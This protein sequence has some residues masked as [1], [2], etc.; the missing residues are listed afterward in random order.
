M[1]EVGKQFESDW[2]SIFS[3]TF[4]YKGKFIGDLNLSEKKF[5]EVRPALTKVQHLLRV[6][7]AL[8]KSDLKINGSQPDAGYSLLEYLARGGRVVFDLSEL[9]SKQKQDFWQYLFPENSGLDERVIS[10]H[11]EGRMNASGGPAEGK[12]IFWGN[13][14]NVGRWAQSKMLGQPYNQFKMDIPA[15]GYG[16][17]ISGTETTVTDDGR[18]GSVFIRRDENMVVVGIEDCRPKSVMEILSRASVENARTGESHSLRAKASKY[19]P[20]GA[21]KINDKELINNQKEQGLLPLTVGSKY[22]WAVAKVT[23]ARLKAMETAA[24]TENNLHEA[25]P[26]AVG[27]NLEQ[28][29]VASQRQKQWQ[30][31]SKQTNQ[32][33]LPGMAKG[34]LAGV[35][36]TGLGIG[37]SLIPG[38]QLA[39]IAAISFGLKSLAVS[40]VM[41][42]AALGVAGRAIYTKF[43]HHQGDKAA[44]KLQT[45]VEEIEP[46]VEPEPSADVRAVTEDL[47]DGLATT[48][49][50]LAQAD[51]Q[52]QAVKS[53]TPSKV[54]QQI[55]SVTEVS[56]TL[57]ADKHQGVPEEDQRSTFVPTQ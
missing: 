27:R 24:I 57:F 8:H 13:F 16:Q 14:L 46:I 28:R 6:L 30:K 5:D 21:R 56:G 36:L 39:G 4:K 49:A 41:I 38:L 25:H 50:N 55:K 33:F 51:Q 23:P 42:G 19:S 2:K 44:Q 52:M 20:F 32:S 53:F 10:S 47:R 11:Y 18:H 17:T 54:S 1:S 3:E 34:F 15:G 22:D 26:G 12:G 35:V 37:L 31:I 29:E 9:G 45:V 7:N 40:F 43:K 48:E